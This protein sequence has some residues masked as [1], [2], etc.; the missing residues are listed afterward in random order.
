M[1]EAIPISAF[2][3]LYL[4][5]IS[6]DNFVV[7][8]VDDGSKN[9]LSSNLQEYDL[10]IRKY[11][12]DTNLGLPAALNTALYNIST[13]FFVRLDADDYVHSKFL[14][15]LLLKFELDPETFAVSV[16]YK[17]VDELENTIAVR[18]SD[19]Y[20]IG[21]GIAFRTEI[22]RNIGLT[23]LSIRSLNRGSH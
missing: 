18:N 6:K 22:L 19:E 5:P 23:C 4:P 9:S 17:L 12:H 8:I 10:D 15:I 21:C 2:N 16:D 3:F 1:L 7:I 13:R 14:E 20:P 11:F